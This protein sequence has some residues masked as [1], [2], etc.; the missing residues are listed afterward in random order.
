MCKDAGF[1]AFNGKHLAASAVVGAGIKKLGAVK[2]GRSRLMLSDEQMDRTFQW[3][4]QLLANRPVTNSDGDVCIYEGDEPDTEGK[5]ENKLEV[6]KVM[7]QISR[8]RSANANKLIESAK[9][10][11]SDGSKPSG[12]SA[13]FMPG[14][15]VVPNA[16]VQIN[17]GATK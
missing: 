6:L 1:I 13:S 17:I 5:F 11:M 14:Q 7:A 4:E 12:I 16:A 10:D 15:K 8:A 3:C 9:V 2:I